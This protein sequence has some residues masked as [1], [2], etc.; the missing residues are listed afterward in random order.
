MDH[1]KQTN[2]GTH[3]L[4]CSSSLIRTPDDVLIGEVS[5]AGDGSRSMMVSHRAQAAGPRQCEEP[6]VAIFTTTGCPY[7]RKA[8]GIFQEEGIAYKEVDVSSDARLRQELEGVTGQ[9]TVP[10]AS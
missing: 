1:T 3:T 6:T 2:K 10:Q 4:L 8:K 9:K 5:S 7:C